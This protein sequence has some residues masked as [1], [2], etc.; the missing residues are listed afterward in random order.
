RTIVSCE[1]SSAQALFWD[2]TF[3]WFYPDACELHPG[4][5]FCVRTDEAT[6]PG[7]G[8]TGIGNQCCYN[9]AGDILVDATTGGG[10]VDKHE[11]EFFGPGLE[12]F[13]Y[14]D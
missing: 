10:T 8:V 9:E 5:A 13:M 6:S 12:P 3:G 11:A 14:N 1:R 2:F 7:G 4:A